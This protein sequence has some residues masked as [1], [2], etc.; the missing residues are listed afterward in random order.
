MIEQRRDEIAQDAKLSLA[1]YREYREEKL[2]VQTAEGAITDLRA[3][4][5]NN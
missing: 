1:E 4:I 3:F 5:Q 2:K